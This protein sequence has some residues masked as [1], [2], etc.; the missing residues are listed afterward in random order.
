MVRNRNLALRTLD[1]R[2]QERWPPDAHAE[3][4]RAAL[5]E[6]DADARERVLR[7]LRGEPLEPDTQEDRPA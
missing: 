4:E 7:L 2:G 3:L 6:P 5:Q 1:Q